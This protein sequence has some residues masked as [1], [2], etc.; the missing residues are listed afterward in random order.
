P[1]SVDA[2]RTA[3]NPRMTIT[4]PANRI[5][6]TNPSRNFFMIPLTDLSAP[7]GLSRRARMDCLATFGMRHQ[8]Q[9]VPR[10]PSDCNVSQFRTRM[11]RIGR[12]LVGSPNTLIASLRETPMHSKIPRGFFRSAISSHERKRAARLA[13]LRQGMMANH[14]RFLNETYES[15]GSSSLHCCFLCVAGTERRGLPGVDEIGGRR[16]GQGS[17]GN[18]RQG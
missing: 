13:A 10:G 1:P 8:E 16:Q 9:S 5:P 15:S 4:R 17:E 14:W 7:I 2:M 6:M 12:R 18:R 11:V 3:A